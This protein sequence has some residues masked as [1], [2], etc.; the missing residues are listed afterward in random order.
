MKRRILLDIVLIMAFGL[1][2]SDCVGTAPAARKSASEPTNTPTAEAP[3]APESKGWVGEH[4]LIHRPGCNC[5]AGHLLGC[6][7]VVRRRYRA[8]RQC[9]PGHPL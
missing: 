9:L 7:R 8:N 1:T 4:V 6:K 5:S 3:K 2:L